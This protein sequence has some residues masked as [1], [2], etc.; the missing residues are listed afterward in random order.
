MDNDFKNYLMPNNL[1]VPL[2]PLHPIFVTNF[3]IKYF[4]NLNF[5]MAHYFA[6]RCVNSFCFLRKYFHNALSL[7]VD[8]V[9]VLDG[10]IG[11]KPRYANQK[12]NYPP[13]ISTSSNTGKENKHIK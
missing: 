10:A 5:N 4:I 3:Y 12:A 2:A 1:P 8:L 13:N 11:I 7:P 6:F 9:N